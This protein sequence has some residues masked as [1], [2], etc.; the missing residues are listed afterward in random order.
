VAVVDIEDLVRSALVELTEHIPDEEISGLV[1]G[2]GVV[3]CDY[4]LKFI[5]RDL[6]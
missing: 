5:G 2:L 6:V 1:F 4:L 3:M